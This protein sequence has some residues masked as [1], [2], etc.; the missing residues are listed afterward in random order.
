MDVED[1]PTTES[2][3]KLEICS[4]FK[5]FDKEKMSSALKNWFT[6]GVCFKKHEVSGEPK[7][8]QLLINLN[9]YLVGCSK[10]THHRC[11][12]VEFGYEPDTCLS[13]NPT[14][15]M[16]WCYKCDMSFEEMHQMYN[17]VHGV[18]NDPR[19]KNMVKFEE[20]VLEL[21]NQFRQGKIGGSEMDEEK[22]QSLGKLVPAHK[23]PSVVFGIQNI[24]NTCFFN[25]TMQ[26]LNA[27]RELVGWYVECAKKDYFEPYDDL[28]R[29]T[30][31]SPRNEKPQQKVRRL[32]P[33]G[34]L[35]QDRF[36]HPPSRSPCGH[37]RDQSEVPLKEPGRRT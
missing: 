19:F 17:E 3:P 31:R 14:N 33:G 28:L 4:H 18:D 11:L 8:P 35:R 32:P 1:G 15:G 6:R 27:T 20:E 10:Y 23:V 2:T 5:A 16:I 26:A 12:F 24:G 25:S 21:L 30:I 22:Q 7:D 29:S 36:V 9:Q 37:L 13:L 34:Q